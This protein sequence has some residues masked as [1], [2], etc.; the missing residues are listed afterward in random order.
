[1]TDKELRNLIIDNYNLSEEDEVL[2]SNG[3]SDAFLG[4]TDI[5]PRRAVYSKQFMIDIVM[6]EDN[7]S[8]AEAIE[9]LEFNTWSTYVGKNTPIYIDT[10][11]N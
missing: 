1:M 5:E 9:W 8:Y 6:K 11:P 2:I 4:I 10:Y 3:Y 7:C